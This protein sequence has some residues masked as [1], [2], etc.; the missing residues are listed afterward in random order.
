MFQIKLHTT[1][2]LDENETYLILAHPHGM[3]PMGNV[4]YLR[5][6]C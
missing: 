5:Q 3:V 2:E 4:M 6:I 1:A